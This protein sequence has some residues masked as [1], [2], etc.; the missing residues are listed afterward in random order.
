E[1]LSELAEALAARKKQVGH[2]WCEIFR[3]Q[4]RNHD[5]CHRV[6]R[7]RSASN[8]PYTSSLCSPTA[9]GGRRMANRTPSTIAKPP[10]NRI[11]RPDAGSS[12]S[13][14]KPRNASCGP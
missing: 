4:T 11:V 7:P 3:T 1:E 6:A 12:T 8:C 14:Q 9:G 2:A 5:H 13:C 10:G